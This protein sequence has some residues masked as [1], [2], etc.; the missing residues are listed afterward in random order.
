MWLKKKKIKRSDWFEGLLKAESLIQQ[1]YE[2][3]ESEYGQCDH[4]WFKKGVYF[5]VTSYAHREGIEDYID[6]YEKYLKNS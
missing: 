4:Y 3:V 5:T 6:F 1:G 2:L